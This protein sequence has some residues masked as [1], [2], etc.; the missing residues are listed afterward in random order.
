M[1]AV[2]K[3]QKAALETNPYL[4]LAAT[5]TSGQM[6]TETFEGSAGLTMFPSGLCCPARI[7]SV[8]RNQ[9]TNGGA[10]R[11]VRPCVTHRV[12]R[13]IV[14]AAIIVLGNRVRT[15]NSALRRQ[16]ICRVLSPHERKKESRDRAHLGDQFIAARRRL[17]LAW[18]S[19]S[20]RIRHRPDLTTPTS[21]CVFSCETRGR[22]SLVRDECNRSLWELPPLGMEGEGGHTRVLVPAGWA[23]DPKGR[24]PGTYH[25]ISHAAW[26]SRPR[27]RIRRS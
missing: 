8:R 12:Y 4:L 10:A 7:R 26:A 2:A 6:P 14:V 3:L 19:R 22:S 11:P 25:S 17:L 24:S 23:A 16:A 27:L 5:D 18:L 20:L 1:L 9:K 15:R 13:G 21:P